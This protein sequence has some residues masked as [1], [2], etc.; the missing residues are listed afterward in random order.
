VLKNLHLTDILQHA[1]GRDPPQRFMRLKALYFGPDNLRVNRAADAT[2]FAASRLR[3]RTNL[4]N[5]NSACLTL[6]FDCADFSVAC[7]SGSRRHHYRNARCLLITTKQRGAP[8][9]VIF[10]M[11]PLLCRRAQSPARP[12]GGTDPTDVDS[13]NRAIVRSCYVPRHHQCQPSRTDANTRPPAFAP[14]SGDFQN[15]ICACWIT[16]RR[17]LSKM[18]HSGLCCGDPASPLIGA[19]R[20]RSPQHIFPRSN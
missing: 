7:A 14:M 13:V 1:L 5:S 10:R 12:N 16:R 2:P 18:L 4:A 9:R 19:L 11:A 6:R 20:R 3:P 17:L 15:G 8:L